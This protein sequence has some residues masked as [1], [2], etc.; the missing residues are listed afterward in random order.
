MGQDNG[1]GDHSRRGHL[2]VI[3]GAESKEL[4]SPIL[5]SVV[6]MAGGRDARLVVITTASLS[7]KDRWKTYSRVF[8]ALGAA[9]V[10]FLHIDTREEANDP[11][12]A[13]L[14]YSSTGVFLTGGDQNRISSILG[15][16][17]VAK[18]MH[19]AHKRGLLISG[20]SAGASAISEHMISEGGAG[21]H[22][23][24]HMLHLSPGLGWLRR[25]VIDQH[26]L[27]RQRLGRLLSIVAQNPFILGIGIDEDTA[28]VVCPNYDF[29]II[30]SGVVTILDG[31][32]ISNSN[33]TTCSSN[34]LLAMMNVR[35]HM[36][37]A[38]NA[39][40]IEFRTP[41][42]SAW[43]CTCPEPQ[44]P[45]LSLEQG[46]DPSKASRRAKAV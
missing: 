18:A 35:L 25:V 45:G 1:S 44:V 9:D 29:R 24:K 37:P 13:N 4:D 46:V 20:T 31:R 33:V 34:D 19:R 21:L 14:V 43:R 6:D 10:R 27:Q 7:A 36:L 3:G 41:L 15:G 12:N 28:I 5:T 38:G 26:F 39:Y 16:T 42:P 11:E 8:R 17:E 32:E 22:P 2:V 40:N 30:G 23:R